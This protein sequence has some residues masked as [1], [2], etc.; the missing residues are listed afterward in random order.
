MSSCAAAGCGKRSENVSNAAARTPVLRAN[1]GANGICW[2]GHTHFN[3]SYANIP[4]NYNRTLTL[5]CEEMGH[6]VGLH[7][8]VEN[9]SCMGSNLDALHLDQH[10]KDVI[11]RLY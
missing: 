4:E 2:N 5:V 8:R 1:G 11:N 7:H 6:A 9:T 10:D 3:T